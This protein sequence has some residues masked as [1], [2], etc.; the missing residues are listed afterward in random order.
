VGEAAEKLAEST[1]STLL[2]QQEV[3]AMIGAETERIETNIKNVNDAAVSKKRMAAFNDN[4]RLRTEQYTQILTVF[5][6][7]IVV[8]LGIT[9]GANYFP[10]IPNAISQ[11]II[12]IIGAVAVIKI[13]MLYQN[14]QSRSLIDFNKLSL[15]RPKID[16]PAEI[17]RAKAKAAKAGDLLGS[18]GEACAGSMCCDT[19]NGVIWDSVSKMCV[20]SA[21]PFTVL[22]NSAS[23][24]SR[25]SKI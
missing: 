11:I 25:Y 1:E 22:P 7:T 5:V 18:I 12:V 15:G 20:Q 14:I 16:N 3:T 10:F 23:E 21:E 4:S 9:I 24:T 2:A 13:F 17:A 8:I 19:K 6:I